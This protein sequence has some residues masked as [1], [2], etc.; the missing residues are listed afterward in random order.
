MEEEPNPENNDKK[1]GEGD[2][3]KGDNNDGGDCAFDWVES[4][5]VV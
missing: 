3:D 1:E 5:D 4:Y 2:D